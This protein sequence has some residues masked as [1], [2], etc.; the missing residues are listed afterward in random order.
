[1]YAL[2]TQLKISNIVRIC[3]IVSE[4][5]TRY[6]CRN[7]KHAC[8]FKKGKQHNI[9]IHCRT[10]SPSASYVQLFRYRA[11]HTPRLTHFQKLLCRI[12]QRPRTHRGS[13][14]LISLWNSNNSS[15]KKKWNLFL[16]LWYQT[17]S[18]NREVFYNLDFLTRFSSESLWFTGGSGSQKT[19]DNLQRIN[20]DIILKIKIQHAQT[21]R[22]GRCFKL[23]FETKEKFKRK[24][25]AICQPNTY[26]NMSGIW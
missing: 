22:D 3:H 25:P 12:I 7:T 16:L 11:N 23:N 17:K 14:W 2:S 9:N 20:S 1:M 10:F 5:S 4:R 26:A 18:T 15:L 24:G 21:K 6:L 13:C 8:I 19:C